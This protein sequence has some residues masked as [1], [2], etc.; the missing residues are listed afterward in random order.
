M[1][2]SSNENGIIRGW[3]K[4]GRKN[5][6]GECLP[7][8]TDFSSSH[9]WLVVPQDYN[10]GGIGDHKRICKHTFHLILRMKCWL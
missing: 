3:I 10:Q 4:D 7:F 5:I 2:F 1:Q 8:H 9:V 6:K